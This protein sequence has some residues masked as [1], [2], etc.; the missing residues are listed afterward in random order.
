MEQTKQVQAYSWNYGLSK[1]ENRILAILEEVS[2]PLRSETVW[3]IYNEKYLRPYA[4]PQSIDRR[5]R[6]L[7]NLGLIVRVPVK[8]RVFFAKNFPSNSQKVQNL[9]KNSPHFRQDLAVQT[10][11][12]QKQKSVNIVSTGNKG[13][14]EIKS[15]R[16]NDNKNK[17]GAPKSI[18]QDNCFKNYYYYN[19]YEYSIG[20]NYNNFIYE[21]PNNYYNN[22]YNFLRVIFKRLLLKKIL[23]RITAG[24]QLLRRF[25]LNLNLGGAV[26]GL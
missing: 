2:S 13:S 26:Y 7:A 6:E 15:I 12:F 23:Q 20:Q 22:N 3:Q 11:D 17:E 21:Y 1:L 14:R 10:N 8:N 16:A 9:T 19:V 18:V 4:S 5:L 25:N 24:N